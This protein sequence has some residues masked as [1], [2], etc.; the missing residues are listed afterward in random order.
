MIVHCK[1]ALCSDEESCDVHEN[2]RG[3]RGAITHVVTNKKMTFD[4]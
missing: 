3:A 2:S 1:S 4:L